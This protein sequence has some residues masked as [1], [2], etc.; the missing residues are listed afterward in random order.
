[1]SKAFKKILD[2]LNIKTQK[3]QSWLLWSCWISAFSHSY[4]W[5][6][7]CKTTISSLPPQWISF[8]GLWLCLSSLLIGMCWKGK[9]RSFAIKWFMHLAVAESALGFLLAMWLC[10]VSWNV[11]VWAVFSLTYISLITITI[12][13]CE[14]VFRS[15]LWQERARELYDNSRSIVADMAMVMGSLLGILL[16]PSL[17]VAL[18]IYGCCCVFD[19]IGWI[20]VYHKTRSSLLREEEGDGGKM[21]G[22][23]S[24]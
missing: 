17:E 8:E 18:F 1:M 7:L 24:R 23:T 20:V 14:M 11:W 19:D 12:Q 3:N 10:F 21:I 5:P 22:S 15:K 6:M 2:L 13:K 4:I 16:V 9:F